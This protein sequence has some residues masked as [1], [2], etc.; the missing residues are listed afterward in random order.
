[1]DRISGRER[2][3]TYGIFGLFAAVLVTYSQT[4][5]YTGDEGFHLLA[6]QSILRGMRPWIDFCFPQAPLNAY[7]N[8][9]WMGLFGQSWRVSHL[10]SS[11]LTVGAVALVADYAGRYLPLPGSWRA[12]AAIAAGLLAGLNAQVF[13]FSP[14]GQAYGLCLL[15]L[16]A[17]FRMAVR[18]QDWTAA[19]AGVFASTAAAASLLCA[20]AVPALF[21]WIALE[22]QWRRCAAFAIGAALP[23]LPVAWLFL[24]GPHAAWFNLVLY[25]SRYRQLY[26]PDTTQHDLEV[27]TSWIDSG[28]SLVLGGLALFGLLWVMRQS[29]WP[30]P[31]KSQICLCGWLAL[32]ICASLSFAHPTFPRYYLLAAPFLAIPAAA[33]LYALGLRMLARGPV[34]PLV[35]ALFLTGAGLAKS[36]YER[37][38]NYTWAD[39]EGIARKIEKATPPHGTIFAGELLYFLMRYRPMSG[40]EFYYDRKIPL[41]PAELARLHILPQAEV[42]RRLSAGVFDTVYLC[43]DEEDYDRLGLA[44]LYRNSEE[45]EDCM[46]FSNRK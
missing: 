27:M 34:W 41:P 30:K 21:L 20:P 46:L 38:E 5:A 6:A 14:L 18:D 10:V 19:A 35:L 26:W 7:W 43:A 8:A 29:D 9:A 2:L 11:L 42:E 16:V 36:L 40:L 4:W 33:G 44:K 22:R 31:L 23:W 28:Q 25:H 1:L 15:L 45:I 3:R 37:R 17:A 32:V 12:A 24:Q 39:Y 13:E